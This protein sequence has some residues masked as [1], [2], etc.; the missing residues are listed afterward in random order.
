MVMDFSA[1]TVS[2]YARISVLALSPP[3]AAINGANAVEGGN[4]AYLLGSRDSLAGIV[5]PP[6]T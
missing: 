3:M 4:G 6:G 5:P 1:M 2:A